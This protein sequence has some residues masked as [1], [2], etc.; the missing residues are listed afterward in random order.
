MLTVSSPWDGMR[1]L[2]SLM[3]GVP[4]DCDDL[5]LSMASVK[6]NYIKC[7]SGISSVASH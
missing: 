3:L 7:K 5:F 2:L 1:G 4:V 6:T